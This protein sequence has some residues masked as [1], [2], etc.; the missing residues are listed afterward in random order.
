MILLCLTESRRIM[1]GRIG[2]GHRIIY[3][4]AGS[5]KTV[6]L[7]ARAK[8]LHDTRSPNAKILLLCYNVVLSVY[9]KHVLKDYP[10]IQCVPFRWVGQTQWNSPA[11]I[12]ILQPGR[13]KTMRV[14]GT[15]CLS[16]SGTDAGIP[17]NMMRSLLMKLRISRPSGSHVFWRHLTIPL[18]A[19][20]WL[21]AMATREFVSLIR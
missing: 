13:L 16:I 15:G 6:L 11:E 10:R 1:P 3:G 18:M 7:I 9:L 17:G 2:E 5:G 19:I 14:L 21:S 4:V 12:K 8:W 20:C